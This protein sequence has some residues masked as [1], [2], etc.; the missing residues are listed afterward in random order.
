M[1]SIL[2]AVLLDTTGLSH[3]SAAEPDYTALPNNF[4]LVAEAVLRC[5]QQLQLMSSMLLTSK[6]TQLL[7]LVDKGEVAMLA[8]A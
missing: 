7:Q 4:S 6:H 3:V 8:T 2:T 1:L 5:R